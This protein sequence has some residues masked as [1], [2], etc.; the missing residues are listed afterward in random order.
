MSDEFIDK[1][2]KGDDEEVSRML[3]ANPSLANAADN[4]GVSPLMLALYYGHRS[5]AE[6]LSRRKGS[7]DLFEAAALGATGQLLEILKN[8]PER[9][10]DVSL[11]GFTALG[12]AAYFGQ[13]EAARLLLQ[14]GADPNLRSQNALSVMPLHSALSACHFDVARILIEAGADINAQGGEGYTPLHYAADRG[15]ADIAELLL[16]KGAQ[17]DLRDAHGRTAAELG[18]EAGHGHV[19]DLIRARLKG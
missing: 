3:D 10:N 16:A 14:A 18:D 15:E 17:T 11:D 5:T 4:H 2:K 1:V 9:A 19:S 13:S 8:H 6:T 12:F 7:L